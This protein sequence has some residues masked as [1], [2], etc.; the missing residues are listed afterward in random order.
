[1]IEIAYPAQPE[2]LNQNGLMLILDKGESEDFFCTVCEL[3]SLIEWAEW[4]C[5]T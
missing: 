1:M 3:F 5:K 4:V 2:K